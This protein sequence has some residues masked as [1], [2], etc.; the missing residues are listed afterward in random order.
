MQYVMITQK[1]R[2]H[3]WAKEP[4]LKSCNYAIIYRISTRSSCSICHHLH[5]MWNFLLTWVP[6][7]CQATLFSRVTIE[8]EHVGTNQHLK[9]RLMGNK[10]D[11]KN[12]SKMFFL[13]C[14]K[15][16]KIKAHVF[17]GICSSMWSALKITKSNKKVQSK[18]LL[19]PPHMNNIL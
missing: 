2:E 9:K 7:V 15:R 4:L 12:S 5:S 19:S 3:F 13:S 14:L 1:I 8:M 18:T 17:S 6:A 16:A 11:I 10:H